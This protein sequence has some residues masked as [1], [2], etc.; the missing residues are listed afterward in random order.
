LLMGLMTPLLA[1]A[2]ATG[3]Q[4]V[5]VPVIKPKN[6]AAKSKV[7]RTTLPPIPIFQDHARELGV[8]RSHIAA[9]AAHYVLDSMSGGAGLFDCDDDDRHDIV[10]AG[11][12]T[13][14]N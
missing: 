11:G 12:S 9:P 7:D 3:P 14:E 8:T 13:D 1:F 10:L 6:S 4:R 2:Q 5:P